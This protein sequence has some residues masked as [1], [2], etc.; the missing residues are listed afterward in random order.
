M[1]NVFLDDMRKTP[2]GFYRTYTVKE[3][4]DILSTEEV[5]ILSLDND[6]GEEQ[7]EGYKV[8]D[9]IEEQIHV[10]PTFKMPKKIIVHSSNPS[11]GLRMRKI[12]SRLYNN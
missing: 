11:A 5:D 1:I 6:L 9:W 2:K 7:E 3:T 8:M 4:I 10:N 12:I